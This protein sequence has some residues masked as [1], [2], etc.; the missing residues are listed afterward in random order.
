MDQNEGI[1][2][3]K[4]PNCKPDQGSLNPKFQA[5]IKRF[6]SLSRSKGGEI[7]RKPPRSCPTHTPGTMAFPPVFPVTHNIDFGSA[8]H[9]LFSEDSLSLSA[10]CTISPGRIVIHQPRLTLTYGAAVESL[11][12]VKEWATLREGCP[13]REPLQPCLD[14][15]S[16][17]SVCRENALARFLIWLDLVL[18]HNSA[19]TILYSPWPR[20]TRTSISVFT[21][22]LFSMSHV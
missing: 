13:G 4:T 11:P 20:I 14:A 3:R 12:H 10:S 9:F 19:K 1:C 22:S 15:I 7:K 5:K 21:F 2:G 8:P 17:C 18:M 6:R 16:V